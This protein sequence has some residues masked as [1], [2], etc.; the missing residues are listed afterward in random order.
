M[1]LLLL[2]LPFAAAFIAACMPAGS[3]SRPAAVAGIATLAALVLAIGQF[4]GI[5]AGEV[6]QMRFAWLPSFGLDIILRMDG[7]A[8]V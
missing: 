6:P 2:L 8:W 7:L 4:G 1:L 5:A 3:R